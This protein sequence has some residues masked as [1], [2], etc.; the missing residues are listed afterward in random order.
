MWFLPTYG[1]PQALE[2]LVNSRG[3]LPPRD[4]LCLLLTEDDPKRADYSRWPF[5]R[6]VVP[7]KSFGDVL[8]W[9]YPHFP[10]QPYYGIFTDDQIPD[11]PLWWE[12][13]AAAAG[14]KFLAVS[15]SVGATATLSGIPCFGGALVRAM[16]SV[17]PVEGVHHNSIDVVWSIIGTEFGLIR[18]VNTVVSLEPHPIHGNVPMD[19]TYE[20]GAFNPIFKVGD[21]IAFDR[22]MASEERALMRTRIAKLLGR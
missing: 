4:T 9:I 5:S 22:W 20:R 7:A 13:L 10:D 11:T 8:R 21:P 6:Y 18:R 16:G 17:L 2:K 15:T 14:E 3:G 12:I 19:A 1:R